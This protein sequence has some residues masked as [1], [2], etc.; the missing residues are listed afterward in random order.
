MPARRRAFTFIELIIVTGIIGAGTVLLQ[1]A[2]TRSREAANRI[3]CASNLRQIGLAIKMYANAER[4]NVYPRTK[5]DPATADKPTAYT[6]SDAANPFFEDGPDANDVSAA[7]F[8]LPRTQEI[9]TDVFNCPSSTAEPFTFAAGK[10]VQNYSNFDS[11]R[12]LSYSYA[13]PYASDGAVAHG[14]AM[15]DAMSADF[16]ILADLNPGGDAVT[17]VKFADG[18][19]RQREANSRNHGRDGQNVLY[20]DGHVEW[21][22]SVWAGCQQDNIYTFKKE[23]GNEAMKAVAGGVY[24]SATDDTDSV[25]L[26]AYDEKVGM[27]AGDDAK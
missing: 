23:P 18:G 17:S 13:N 7:L 14:Y 16:A 26:P 25:M 15:N 10:T 19:D 8:L 6:R 9:S 27:P 24:G 2:L 22:A 4:N 11:Q 1:P 12:H 20:A 5:Y 21:S 3:K